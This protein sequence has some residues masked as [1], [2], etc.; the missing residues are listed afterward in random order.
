ME[1]M[2]SNFKLPPTTAEDRRRMLV[3]KTSDAR[4]VD[5]LQAKLF[6]DALVSLKLTKR[7]TNDR[8]QS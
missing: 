4:A 3:G 6:A 8:A 2:H 1:N 5:A 7:S